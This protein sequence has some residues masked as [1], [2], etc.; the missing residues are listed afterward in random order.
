MTSFPENRFQKSPP[1]IRVTDVAKRAGCA[2]ATVSRAINNPDSVSPEKR[3]KIESAMRELGYV[4]NY[5]ARA[6]RSQRSH[7][8]GIII[9][10]L[11]YAIY[12]QMVEAAQKQLSQEGISTLIATFEYDLEI[13]ASEAKSLLERGA[14]ALLLVGNQHRPELYDLLARFEVPFVNTYVFDR[15]SPHPNVG[16]DNAAAAAEIVRH[17]VHIGH[18]NIGVI[19]GLTQDND[20][21]A[22]RLAGIKREIGRNGLELPDYRVAESS[23]SIG[24]GREALALLLSRQPADRHHLRQRHSCHRCACRM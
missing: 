21:T 3:A 10:T 17:L 23:Y 11:S 13:E 7:M 14:E 1:R 9:P 18:K 6:L 2:T 8:I 16:F 15:D 12:A 20:R 4:R 5:A 19:S 24:D 22:E